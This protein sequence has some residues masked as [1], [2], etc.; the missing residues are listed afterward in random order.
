MSA[1][2]APSPP[3][4]L[5]LEDVAGAAFTAGVDR[6]WWR[7]AIVE[8]PHAVIEVKAAPRPGSSDWVALR[9]EL[10][11]YPGAPSAQPWDPERRSMLDTGLWP[12]GSARILGAFRPEWR[13]DA[14]YMPMDGLALEAHPDWR[15]IYARDA[16]DSGKDITQYLR[17]V[18]ELINQDGYTG[19]RA[20]G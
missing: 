4:R 8:W 2:P 16:W 7:L 12:G 9:F 6:G 10:S 18:R 15:S 11:G 14:L 20:P 5:F 13:P 17:A 1:Q 3:E 19:V